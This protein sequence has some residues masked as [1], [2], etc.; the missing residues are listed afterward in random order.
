MPRLPPSRLRAAVI[1]LVVAVA[2]TGCSTNPPDAGPVPLRL[3]Y[4]PNLTHATAILGVE[5][6]TFQRAVG[7]G[8]KLEPSLFTSGPP[9][10]TAILSD[11]VDAVFVG[12]TPAVN[13]F[14]KTKGNVKIVSGATSGGAQLVVRNGIT[15]AADLKGRTIADPALGGAPDIQLRYWLKQHGLRTGTAG[16]GDVHISPQDNAQMAAAY[17]SGA[18]DGAWVPQPYATLLVNRGAHVLVNE[19]SLWPG[20]RFNTTNLLVRADFLKRHP[21]V[22][23]A[24]LRGLI[25]ETDQVNTD[26]AQARQRADTAIDKI[27]GGGLKEGDLRAAW[28]DMT[29][30]VDPLLA[31]IK[32]YGRRGTDVGVLPGG[33][34]TRLADLGPLNKALRAEGKAA[35]AG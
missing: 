10:I 28:A 15:S 20:G 22:V 4:F 24:L 5:D 21:D 19:H 17:A 2:V 7:S 23:V 32:E 1:A 25:K 18:I 3:G 12:A 31:T 29:F 16:D 26:P 30:T 8:V 6:G 11:A 27:N 13:A 33:D 35:V 34:L 14:H 9:A